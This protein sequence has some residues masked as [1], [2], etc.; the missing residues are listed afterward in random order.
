MPRERKK[1]KDED[2]GA[3]YLTTWADMTTL[4]LC[5]F[6][7]LLAMSSV[8]PAKFMVAA[9]SFQN[10]FSGILESMPTIP[11]HENVLRPR[12]GGDEQNKRMAINAKRRIE[13]RA[14]RQDMDDAVKVKV[15]EKGLAIR[16]SDPVLFDVGNAA[17]KPR[18]KELLYNVGT[19]INE[20]TTTRIRVEGHT[21]NTPI[22]TARYPSNWDLSAA[23]ALNVVKFLAR[24]A[25]I[26]PARLSAVGYGEYHPIVPNTSP[27]NRQRNRRI[28]IYVEYINKSPDKQL[29]VD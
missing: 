11:I 10:A 16:I 14:E 19:I 1:K 21:D 20:D 26:D 18:F 12:M 7:M 29:V 23:R 27:E 3:S 17:L 5:F 25:G 24:N 2:S 28:E 22:N 15:T 4:L 9:S 8:N 6:V 13:R